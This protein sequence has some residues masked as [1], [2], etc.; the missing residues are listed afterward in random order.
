[1]LECWNAMD[2]ANS[3][4]LQVAHLARAQV[5]PP[6]RRRLRKSGGTGEELPCVIEYPRGSGTDLY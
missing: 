5:S 6:H 1:M 3:R 4:T 2:D